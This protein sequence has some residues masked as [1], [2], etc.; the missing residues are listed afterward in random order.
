MSIIIEDDKD[1]RGLLNAVLQ[2]SGFKVFTAPN[3]TEGVEAVRTHIPPSLPWIWGC[4]ILT[5]LK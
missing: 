5:A 1:I 3:G 4:R 2:Q